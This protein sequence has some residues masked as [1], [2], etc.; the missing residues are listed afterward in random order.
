MDAFGRLAHARE[1][2]LGGDG[3]RR[4]ERVS[5]TGD[6]LLAAL[7]FPNT[8]GLSLHAVLAAE[9]ARVLRVLLNL[10]L[11]DV[12]SQR[13]AISRA[14]LSADSYLLGALPHLIA[15]K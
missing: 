10:H 12:F 3:R 7:A 5:P 14:V 1:G 15:K 9:Y 6:D 4:V 13:R 8:G 11:L 2:R